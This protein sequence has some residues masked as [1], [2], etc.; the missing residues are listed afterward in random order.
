DAKVD[1]SPQNAYIR[2]LQHELAARHA[3]VSASNGREP[4]RYVTILQE[5]MSPNRGLPWAEDGR[6]RAR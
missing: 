4:Y 2:R 3:L 1:L 6:R 5:T